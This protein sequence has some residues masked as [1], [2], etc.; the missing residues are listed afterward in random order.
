VG[1]AL[2]R[3][4][5]L[6]LA[7]LF[8]AAALFAQGGDPY[9]TGPIQGEVHLPNGQPATNINLQIEPQG[10]GGVMES[11]ST[12]SAGHFSF[13]GQRIGAGGN[14]FIS[15]NVQGYQ[16]V[17]EL[18]MV[19]G[20]FTYLD[21]N[22]VPVAGVK[23]SSESVISVKQL[24]LPPAALEEYNRG[25][26]DMDQGKTTQAEEA[27]KKA[28]RIDPKFA[29]SYLR[30]SAI[31]TDQNRF[32]DAAEAIGRAEAIDHDNADNYAFLGYFYLKQKQP[33]KA[34]QSLEK[35]IQMAPNRWFAHLE[36]GRLLYDRKDYAGALPHLELAHNL[37][38]QVASVHL[39]LY[40]DLIRLKKR[41][42]ALAELDDFI[43]RFPNSHEAARMRAVR[44]ALAAA[45][46]G[47]H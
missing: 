4:L 34:R 18:V 46:A 1:R 17:H 31:Y 19:T 2:K 28:I 11:T 21:I 10:M 25:L 14:Y 12:D 3:S 47:Q 7:L 43:A 23:P 44:P 24:Q 40:D 45:V 29:A 37:H 27:F 30:L 22:L 13:T 33:E 16:P 15:V 35:S 5:T 39:L 20:P 41:Q 42:E 6:I 8:S 26:Q 38:P 36:L 9:S 32:L